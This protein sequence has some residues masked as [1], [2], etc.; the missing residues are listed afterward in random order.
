MSEWNAA[1]SWGEKYRPKSLDEVV[2]QKPVLAQIRGMIKQRN[3]STMMLITG[4]SGL[5]KTSLSL[6]IAYAINELKYGE[7]SQDIHD[8]NIG[9]EGGKD[10][11]LK[12]LQIAQ[13]QPSRNFRVI[14]LDEAHKLSTQALSALLKPLEKGGGRTVWIFVTNEPQKLLGTAIG[15]AD[16][17]IL[18]GIEPEELL[19][20][21]KTICKAE[22]LDFMTDKILLQI[23]KNA[24]SQPRAAINL[25]QST[26]NAYYGADKDL[27][28]ALTTAI[29]ATGAGIDLYAAKI[30]ACIYQK[31]VNG[32]VKTLKLIKAGEFIGLSNYLLYHSAF[33]IEGTAG[34]DTWQNESRKKLI[35]SLEG[36]EI[37]MNKMAKVHA[38]LV[39]IKKELFQFQVPEYD[40]LLSRLL[41]ISME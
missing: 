22:K 5:G 32:I 27:K 20:R 9:A 36:K 11:V 24:N 23:A 15:R 26:V 29:T 13:Y 3:V 37:A 7:P 6:L 1:E 17:L 38:E 40:L 28:V 19:P 30:L 31:R 39:A 35:A 21:L 8:F 2:G 34:V 12:I 18:Q 41:T 16:K 4:E 33:M 25:L 14:I 10:D